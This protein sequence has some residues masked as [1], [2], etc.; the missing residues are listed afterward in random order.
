MNKKQWF[1][2]AT[3]VCAFNFAVLFWSSVEVPSPTAR[4]VDSPISTHQTRFQA[5]YDSQYGEEE[6]ENI[7]VPIPKKDRIFNRTGTQC[8]WVSLE[9]VGRWAEE[10][11][12][13][14]PPISSRPE[15]QSYANPS[16]VH[17][18]LTKLG[19]K[20]EQTTSGLSS[21]MAM[22]KK[23]TE[24]GRGCVFT[25]PGH[26]MTMLHF[27]E[28]KDEVKWV[29]NVDR[30]LKVQTTKISTYK[31]YWDTWVIIIYPDNEDKLNFK[32]QKTAL[33]RL[34]PIIDRNNEQGQYPKD[35]IPIP[36][37]FVP[38]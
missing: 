22:M 24:S 31:R 37:L 15:C 12:L 8:V 4:F 25:I 9:T 3:A 17:R 21:A 5:H 29:D 16:S 30:T 38:R 23:A 14:D 6:P 36:S 11:K 20:F 10:P 33:P 1:I 2:V 28:A 7:Q 35:Y 34:L 19:V 26:A 32:I 18:V 27:D 13:V